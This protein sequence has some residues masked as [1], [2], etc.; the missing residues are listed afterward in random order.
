MTDGQSF[1]GLLHTAMHRIP[2]VPAHA[3][4]PIAHLLRVGGTVGRRPS[5]SHRWNHS[6]T[7]PPRVMATWQR[8][9][10]AFLGQEM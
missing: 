2:G 7:R 4:R 10:A 3:E 8:R 6:P 5:L 1:R 9:I